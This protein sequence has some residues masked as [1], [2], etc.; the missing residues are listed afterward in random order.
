MPRFERELSIAKEMQ[1]SL[2][3]AASS[4]PNNAVGR[5]QA[6]MQPAKEVGGDFFDAWEQKGSIWFTVADVSGKGVGARLVH[7]RGIHHSARCAQ[8]RR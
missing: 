2:L 3:P 5:V 7:G 6:K 1:D 4:L 8:T